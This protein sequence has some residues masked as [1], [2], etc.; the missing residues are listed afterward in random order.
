VEFPEPFDAIPEGVDNFPSAAVPLVI[1]LPNIKETLKELDGVSLKHIYLYVYLNTGAGI[2]QG[3]VTLSIDG[4]DIISGTKNIKN[5]NH[6]FPDMANSSDFDGTSYNGNFDEFYLSSHPYTYDGLLTGS[7][8]KNFTLNLSNIK[9][10]G[11]N[12]RTITL[13]FAIVLPMLFDVERDAVVDE[14]VI[15]KGYTE[16]KLGGDA[17]MQMGD[18]DFT[19][20]KSL[21]IKIY[22]IR[23]GLLDNVYISA[24]GNANGPVE[25]APGEEGVISFP[26]G[27]T[28]APKILLLVPDA[29]E[30]PVKPNT[31]PKPE[32]DFS[33]SVRAV[34]EIDY[35]KEF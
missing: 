24:A 27:L 15:P 14:D 22:N 23:N 3:D 1:P 6:P 8:D 29:K 19:I 35:E 33:V 9:T 5:N 2:R 30:L 26:N 32:F 17:D 25:L 13:E 11:N 12:D 21:D 7:G 31:G 18:L 20:L 34:A 16:L 4:T 28:A 10:N